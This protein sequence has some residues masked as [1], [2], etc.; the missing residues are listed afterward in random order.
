MLSKTDVNK[1]LSVFRRKQTPAAFA[2]KA[3]L[4]L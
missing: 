1:A 3:C 4:S 2:L